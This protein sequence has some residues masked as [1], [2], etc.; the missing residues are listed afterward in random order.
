MKE[1][2]KNSVIILTFCASLLFSSNIKAEP[3][4]HYFI[5]N[6]LCSDYYP[7]CEIYTVKCD[8]EGEVLCYASDQVPCAEYC[9]DPQD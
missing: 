5:M 7:D 9:E 3:E 6:D 2:L 8:Y 4:Y 1:Y